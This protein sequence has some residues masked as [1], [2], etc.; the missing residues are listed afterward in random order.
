MQY[1]V[2]SAFVCREPKVRR[3]GWTGVVDQTPSQ[4][5]KRRAREEVE[6]AVDVPA[7][8]LFSL[9]RRDNGGLE[10]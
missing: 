3:G 6:R 4:R 8:G 2:R 5:P 9:D 10:R 1:V 7:E